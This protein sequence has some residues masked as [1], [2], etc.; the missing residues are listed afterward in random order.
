MTIDLHSSAVEADYISRR[1]Y[2][3]CFLKWYSESEQVVTPSLYQT[4]LISV[5]EFLKGDNSTDECA[6]LFKEY[7]TCLTVRFQ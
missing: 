3:T 7:K 6:P 2:D 5:S 1:R 4:K